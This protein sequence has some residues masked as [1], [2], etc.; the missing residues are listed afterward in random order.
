MRVLCIDV[1][2]TFLKHTMIDECQTIETVGRVETP[3]D[4]L[5][6]FLHAIWTI[7]SMYKDV[8]GIAISAPGIIDTENGFMITGGSLDYIR[9]I[10]MAKKI[11]QLCDN[12]PVYIE[13]DAKAAAKAELFS[14]VLKN[15]K[16]GVV[17][18]FGTAIGGTVI[19]N[20]KV[21]RG[22]N[23]FAGEL[24]YA[25][26]Q[27]DGTRDDSWNNISNMWG[28][29][30]VP[31][32]IVRLY[33]DPSLNCEEILARLS[34]SDP[35]A[36]AAVRTAAKEVALLAHNLQCTVDPDIIAIGG[37]VSVQKDF[38]RLVREENEKLNAVF[39]GVVPKPH[40]EPCRYFNDANLLGAYHAFINHRE[41]IFL[42]QSAAC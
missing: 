18:T 16:N 11:S 24:S 28:C 14:G 38:I 12:L 9:D 31:A 25:I 19:V 4:N 21:L 30:G 27:D 32:Q 29:R 13:N 8:S 33:G 3:R 26:Y 42:P 35:K 17:L 2:G 6:N 5:E 37:G 34:N 15:V 36:D 22:S 10:P 41:E 23:L 7:Y 20:R 39:G 1:G 40:I